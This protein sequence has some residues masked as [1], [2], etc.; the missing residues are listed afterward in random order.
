MIGGRQLVLCTSFGAFRPRLKR[1]LE[2]DLS[3]RCD[4]TSVLARDRS[5]ARPIYVQDPP[6]GPV[7]PG[8]EAT[9]AG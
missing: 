9:Q 2:F 8:L 1:Y 3:Q 6:A 4:P 5:A 7:L